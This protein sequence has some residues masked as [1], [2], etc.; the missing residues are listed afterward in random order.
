MASGSTLHIFKPKNHEPPTSNPATIDLRNAQEVLD[1]DGTTNE[2][3][4]FSSILNRAYSGGGLT[5][6]CH[7]A[8][9]SATSGDVIFTAAIER[10]NTDMD[11]DSFASAQTSAAT[12]V[13]G[14]SGITVPVTIT[15]SSGANMDSLA[16]GEPFRIEIIRNAA[17]GSD[18]V[19]SDVELTCVEIRET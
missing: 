13:S 10:R 7:V 2:A 8:A 18:T 4:R 9:T 19:A 5:V 15:L 17:S 16:A 6:I 14:T 11:S 3:T 12:T 1:F